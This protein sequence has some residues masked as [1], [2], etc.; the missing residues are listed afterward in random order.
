[1]HR[2]GNELREALRARLRSEREALSPS[3]VR[4]A[5]EAACR[6][7]AAR[8]ELARARLVALYAATRGEIDPAPLAPLCD[9]RL[10]YPRVEH[11]Q[12]PTLAFHRVAGPAALE[13]GRFGIAAP[14]PTAPRVRLDEIELVVV[15]AVAF[16][17][18]GHRLGFGRGYYD[19]ALA[20]APAALRVGLCHGFQLVDAL[21]PRPGDQPVDLVVTPDGVLETG[22]R[23]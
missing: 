2:A 1:V 12:P 14:A 13:P 21:E 18:A 7:L 11:E 19:A 17:R 15:P 16:D 8:A 3:T 5:S 4:A 9:G 22:A 6:R 23:G 20:A 10:C